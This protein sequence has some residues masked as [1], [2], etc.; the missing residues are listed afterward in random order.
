MIQEL[1]V[2]DLA[3]IAALR[4]VLSRIRKGRA[5]YVLKEDN[6]PLAMLLSLDE[7]EQRKKD[8]EKAWQDLFRVMDKV[9]AAN[10]QFP[11]EEVEADVDATIQELRRARKQR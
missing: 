5:Q 6:E 4:D 8:K 3:D 7:V 1:D 2:K 11:S 9:H 10:A